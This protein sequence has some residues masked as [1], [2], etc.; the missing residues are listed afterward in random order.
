MFLGG[1]ESKRS[2]AAT[3]PDVS[4]PPAEPL[5]VSHS[6]RKD[7]HF[8]EGNTIVLNITLIWFLNM[9]ISMKFNR[10]ISAVP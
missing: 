5:L 2:N 9:I 7:I 3:M 6:E 4:P 10:V 8:S 1:N